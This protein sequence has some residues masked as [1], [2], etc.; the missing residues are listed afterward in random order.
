MKHHR[1][2]ALI[3]QCVA[4]ASLPAQRPRHWKVLGDTLGAPEGCSASAAIAAID[5]WFNAFAAVDS[6]ALGHNLLDGANGPWVFST[7]KFAPTDKFVRIETLPRLVHYARSRARAH[8]QMRLRAVEFYGWRGRRL[9]FMPFFVRSADDLALG[10]HAGF[11][12]AGFACGRGLEKL[13]LAPRP[14]N[15]L[16]PDS[17]MVRTPRG[18]ERRP[19][20]R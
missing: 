16:G 10:E 1:K 12:K 14:S 5:H 9:T 18:L 17:I 11:G 6:V 4:L 20:S 8:E 3:L 7:G 19:R 2:V 13:N 15:A